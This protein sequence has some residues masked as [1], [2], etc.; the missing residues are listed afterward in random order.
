MDEVAAALV[1][2]YRG[3]G[4]PGDSPALDHFRFG[5]LTNGTLIDAHVARRLGELKPAFVQ[6]SL[7][8]SQKTN[9][10]IRGAGTF[11]RI[12]AALQHLTAPMNGWESRVSKKPS[13]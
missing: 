8:G 4:Q 5:I 12:T 11:D 6:V 2:M 13:A 3:Q 9:D 7:E 1:A 10:A